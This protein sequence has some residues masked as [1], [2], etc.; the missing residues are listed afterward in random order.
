MQ[1][2]FR[3]F[4]TKDHA[5]CRAPFEPMAPMPTVGDQFMLRV[6]ILPAQYHRVLDPDDELGIIETCRLHPFP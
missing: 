1:F 4:R 5:L 6:I 3:R 2:R